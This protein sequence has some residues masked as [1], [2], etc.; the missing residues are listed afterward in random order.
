[1]RYRRLYQ[2]SAYLGKGY[3]DELRERVRRIRE[4]YGLQS[5]PVEYR[6]EVWIEEQGELFG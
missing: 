4:R 3:K 6:P 1:V 5:G 2:N